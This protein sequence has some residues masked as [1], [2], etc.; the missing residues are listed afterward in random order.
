M[1]G[2]T[3]WHQ[4]FRLPSGRQYRAAKRTGMRETPWMRV[5]EPHFHPHFMLF[6]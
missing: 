6:F 1:Q 4:E 3:R 5:K 2:P